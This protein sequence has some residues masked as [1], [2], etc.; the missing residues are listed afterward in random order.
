MDANRKTWN[1]RQQE[2]RW[3]L[4]KPGSGQRGLDLFLGQHAAVHAAGVSAEPGW[5][6]ADEVLAGASDTSMRCIPPKGEHSIAWVLWHI[7]RIEDMTM[8]LLVAAECQVFEQDT[9]MECLGVDVRDT[10]NAMDAQAVADFSVRVDLPALLAYRMA[11]GRA[12]QAVIRRLAPEQ[13][14]ERVDPARLAVIR[15]QGGVAEG[16]GWLLDYWGS[17]SMAQL[18][19]MPPTRHNFLHLNEILRIRQKCR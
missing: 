12:T 9:W 16:C 8:N 7:A 18:L 10:G 15:A 13:L 17:L 1:E 19:L 3:L 11:V 4:A 5:S 6:F 14:K 2:L